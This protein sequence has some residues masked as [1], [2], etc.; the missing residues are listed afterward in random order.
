[1]KK[2]LFI[3]LLLLSIFSIG[4]TRRQAYI[5]EFKEVAIREMRLHNIPASITLAQG[6][7]ES[8]DGTS[9]L[10]TEANNH[11]GIK[12]HEGWEGDRIYHDDDEK[13]E[14]FRKYKNPEESYK[15]HSTF[16]TTRIRYATLFE[17]E[18][19]D[20]KGWAKGLQKAGY[21]TSKTYA[22]TL[23]RLIEQNELYRYDVEA[24]ESD[25]LAE[26]RIQQAAN[27]AK[28][29]VVEEGETL[30]QLSETY[31]R[32]VKK[33]LAFNDFTY[34]GK[35]E[36]GDRIYIRPKKRAGA[37]KTYAVEADDTMHNIAQKEGIKLSK[38]YKRN[39]KPVGW[40]PQVGDVLRLRGWAK[41]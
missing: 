37:T 39:R 4:Q 36:A 34:E 31:N 32:S 5:L 30:E 24:L 15:D 6:I 10:A 35:I 16:L 19:T 12:C 8:G 41:E 20:Y 26:A 28:Y 40:Q 38:L 2:W 25:E 7:L 23:I 14:C 17:L 1:M 29:V 18:K 22:E 33:L 21:A 3:L 9:R 27:G 13:G 11:F